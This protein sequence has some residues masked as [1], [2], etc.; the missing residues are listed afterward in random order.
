[1]RRKLFKESFWTTIFVMLF[2]YGL[3]FIP[4]N[5]DIINPISKA[6]ADFEL[7][8]IVF[9]HMRANP[10]TEEHVT[11]VNIG[12][13]DRR[14][15]AALIEE[16]NVHHPKVI[17]IDA[18]F[19]N[20][21]EDTEGDSL[22]AT[23]F[24]KVKHMVIVSQ[25]KADEEKDGID[26]ILYS[27][28][29]FQ[30]HTVSG[31]ANMITEGEDK[32]K[33]SRDCTPQETYNGKRL[34]SF[35]VTMCQFYDSTKT[36]RFLARNNPTETI[37]FQG[38]IDT[39]LEG[40]GANSKNVFTAI[41]FQQVFDTLY[42]PSIFKDKIVILGFMGNYIGDNTAWVDK[43][44]TPLNSNYVGK[45]NQDMYGVVVHAN[46]VSMIL[47]ESYI[48][49]MPQWLNLPLSLLLIFLNV[50]L[51]SW[52]FIKMEIW[53]DGMTFLLTIIEVMIL[54]FIVLMV[55]DFNNYRIDI[56]L[57]SIAL[58]LT[59]NLVEIYYGLIKPLYSKI[60]KKLVTST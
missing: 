21:K 27:H 14:G 17:G 50:W 8:D 15:V 51:Y 22:L 60:V 19:R 7:T 31:F 12:Q 25:L 52:L 45:A 32:F 41:D 35:P 59:G 49:D 53:Y 54:T 6:L 10:G 36:N 55:F 42:D 30:K 39:R 1:M 29:M 46:I 37:N 3:S 57:P 5:F 44:F 47:K 16:I 43:F 58:A 34:L 2:M 28:P 11:I 13:L 38:N 9:S 24:S 56:T 48:D 18:F 26:T 40:V 4:F 23:A 33:T 20:P